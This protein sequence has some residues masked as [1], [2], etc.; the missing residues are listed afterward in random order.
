MSTSKAREF[1][2]A[3]NDVSKCHII[4]H[5]NH[6]VYRFIPMTFDKDLVFVLIWYPT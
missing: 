1:S 4:K 3:I 6:A 2:L 5:Y